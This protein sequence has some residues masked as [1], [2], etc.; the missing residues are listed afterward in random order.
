MTQGSDRVLGNLER[1]RFRV[2]MRTLLLLARSTPRSSE[3]IEVEPAVRPVGLAVG[4]LLGVARD[5]RRV[6]VGRHEQAEPVARVVARDAG[7]VVVAVDADD[8]DGAERVAVL[9]APARPR[10]R[11]SPR[12]TAC[13]RARPP[14]RAAERC[15][16]PPATSSAVIAATQRGAGVVRRRRCAAGRAGGGAAPAPAAARAGRPRAGSR[17][18]RAARPGTRLGRAVVRREQHEQ[19]RRRPA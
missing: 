1:P 16:S 15:A 9:A 6:L 12:A 13:S 4:D 3:R 10:R 18:P 11:A 14:P 8:V 19:H 5:A 7:A 17:S 2:A